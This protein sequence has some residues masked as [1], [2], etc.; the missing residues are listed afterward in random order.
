MAKKGG[1]D[2]DFLAD[3]KA[4]KNREEPVH[5]GMVMTK[6]PTG[7]SKSLSEVISENEVSAPTTDDLMELQST[8]EI[9]DSKISMATERSADNI[10]ESKTL[11]VAKIRASAYQ[12]RSIADPEYIES[13]M[14]SIVESGV[15]SPIVV[16]PVGDVFEIIA[17]HH[18]FEACSRLGYEMVP[19]SIQLMT[20]SEAA[21]ALASDN[22]VR[23]ELCDYERY[24]HAKMLMDLGFCKT[25]REAGTVLGVSPSTMTNLMTFDRF[26]DEAKEYLELHPGILGATQAKDLEVIAIE[27]PDLLTEALSQVATNKLL[28]T[29]IK[30]W[31]ELKRRGH[32]LRLPKRS[33]IKI[34]RPELV[35][36]I[37][38]IFTE[39]EAKIQAP[40]LKIDELK[41]LI[42]ENIDKLLG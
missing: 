9:L 40:G 14:E 6:P 25:R 19:V 33:E 21:K 36:P 8:A 16:R 32:Q 3:M 35:S 28:Q 38:L 13:L 17:G 18:R 37:R 20:D 2:A 30:D 4:S 22:L 26:P 34:S 42:E 29:K 12:V 31:I 27:S 10:L 7:P 23:K 11:P 39:N 41:S 15:I 5:V 24:K 1:S